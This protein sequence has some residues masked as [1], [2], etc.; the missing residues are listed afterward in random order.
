M[1]ACVT[2]TRP[3]LVDGTGAAENS[4]NQYET[5]TSPV[6]TAQPLQYKKDRSCQINGGGHEHTIFAP[7]SWLVLVGMPRDAPETIPVTVTNGPCLLCLGLPDVVCTPPSRIYSRRQETDR[8]HTA[9]D[10]AGAERA[11]EAPHSS[12]TAAGTGHP[13]GT[14]AQRGAAPAC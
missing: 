6:D 7:A 11:G 10:T 13:P 12:S 1:R 14:A 2:R 8:Q 9:A 3:E 4:P 5:C